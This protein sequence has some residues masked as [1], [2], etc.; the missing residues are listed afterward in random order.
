MESER[1]SQL[2]EQAMLLSLQEKHQL[3]AFLASQLAQDRAAERGENKS[4]QTELSPE[5]L[6]WKV[7]LDWLKAHREEYAGNYV[8]LDGGRLVG[9]GKTYQEARLAATQSGVSDAFITHIS[10]AADVPLGGW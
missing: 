5:K 9:T 6:K 10:S 7:R 1:L 8:A 3:A 4:D 2:M